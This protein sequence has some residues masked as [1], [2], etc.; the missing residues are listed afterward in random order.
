MRFS[1][2]ILE[3]AE[4]AIPMA[5][6]WAARY[7][8][9]AGPALDLTQAVP[10]YPPHPELLARLG[11]AAADRSAA[12]YGPIAGDEALRAEL[13]RDASGFYGAAIAP[14]HVAITAGCN[15]A[16]AMAMKVIAAP[17]E[18]VLLPTP[19]YFN[20][21]MALRMA[22]VEAR[23]LPCRA[24]DGFVPDAALAAALV[25]DK[26]R[27]ILLVSPNNPT[28]AV[29][30]PAVIAG[31]AEFAR[32]RGIWL[33]LDET[34][35]DFLPNA[36]PHHLFSAPDWTDMLVHLYSFSKAYCIPGHR[37]GAVIAGEAFQD[38]LAKALD[39]LQICPARPAQRVLA[40]AIPAL[41]D[42]R[43]DNR[44]IMQHRAAACRAALHAERIDA[45][46]SYFAY[47]RLPD[48]APDAMEAAE[49]LAAERGLMTLP[50][51]FFGPGQ[52]RH[53]RLAFANAEEGALRELGSRFRFPLA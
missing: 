36:V 24:E 46:G 44:K 42:W 49:F 3:T 2:A 8:G 10:G 40:W 20:H 28:G 34:Y 19:W 13:A 37:L 48:G 25:D 1:P 33:V 21:E 43:A 47:L 22:G 23:P 14:G 7:R 18:N 9:Q 15:L 30:P 29:Y 5:R 50:G 26:T 35:R 38:Q 4:P 27:A 16:F 51:P 32:R 17:G 52:E 41:R 6:A 12:G 39:T 31:F 53:L 45:M 11:E